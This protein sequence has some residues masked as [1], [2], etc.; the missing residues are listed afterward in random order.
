[1]IRLH[2][3]SFAYEA[4][5]PILKHL[6]LSVAEG[7]SVGIVGANGAGKSTLLKLLVG[8]IFPD[9]M[10][11]AP[12]ES[13]FISVGD[14]HV[15]K[16]ELAAVRKKIGYVF[17][18]SEAQLFMPTVEK[19]VGFAP[20]N[21]GLS[22]QE[23]KERVDEALSLVG[24]E[25]LRERS[26]LELSGGQKKLVS[27]ATVLSMRPEVLL[28]DEPTIALDPR[29]RRRF[30]EILPGLPG[31]KLIVSHD[32]DLVLDTCERTILLSDGTIAADGP[33]KEIL[34]DR[35]L[36]EA[37]GLELPLFIQGQEWRNHIEDTVH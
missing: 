36:L 1:M 13:G 22:K 21:Y 7:E 17:Q 35:R 11:T 33:S 31:T 25:D 20:K 10:G 12:S 2:D 15:S 32:L 16:K 37:N 26:V 23:V 9:P 28:F 34:S 14:I 30:I 18:D 19:D 3:V 5:H 4:S 24:I 6:D 29:N 27:L 8:L